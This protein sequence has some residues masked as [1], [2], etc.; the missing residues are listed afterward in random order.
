MGAPTKRRGGAPLKARRVARLLKASPKAE[1]RYVVELDAII[2]AIHKGVLNVV[3]K[4]FPRDGSLRQDAGEGDPEGDDPEGDDPEGDDLPDDT[5]PTSPATIGLGARLLSLIYAWALPRIEESYDRMAGEVVLKVTNGLSLIGIDPHNAVGIDSFIEHARA[6]NVELIK[7]ASADFLAQVRATLD[8]FEGRPAKDMAAALQ[9]RV[10]VSRSRAQLIAR[11]QVLKL[12]AAIVEHRCRSAGVDSYRWSTSL[13]ERVRAMHAA[14]EGQT[15]TWDQPPVTN[16]DGEENH[17]GEDYQCFPEGSDVQFAHGV[18]KGFRRRFDGELSSV[19]L[20]SGK[21]VRA[22][23]NH[24]VLTQRGWIS[25]GDL[26]LSDYILEI[27]DEGLQSA[28]Q[29]KYNRVPRICE[30]F[31]ALSI[32]GVRRTARGSKTHFHGDGGKGDVNIVYAARPLSFGLFPGGAE[33]VEKLKLPSSNLSGLQRGSIEHLFFGPGSTPHSRVCG[34]GEPQAFA[35][36]EPR[37]SQEAGLRTR[38]DIHPGLFQT[39]F[40]RDARNACAI[41]DR[42][43]ALACPVS[44][45]DRRH[46]DPQNGPDNTCPSISPYAESSEFL[47]QVIGRNAEDLGYFLQG[48]PLVQKFVRV[49]RIDRFEFHGFVLNLETTPGWYVA[50]GILAKNC[51]CLPIPILPTDESDAES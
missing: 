3:K 49:C 44:L 41:R 32:P 30:V 8:E 42:E 38:A 25:L 47:A 26:Q 27:A 21:T 37:H 50:Q 20:E 15:F 12:N 14:L 23:Q 9:A 7:N 36:R 33:G 17:P 28:K 34:I 16:D 31:A 6:A 1:M 29:D 43:Q 39:R 40:K 11:D 10:E 48:L 24:P 22:T 51:R 35:P 2:G 46:V 4:E 13:D 19:I 5:V 45:D 18:V